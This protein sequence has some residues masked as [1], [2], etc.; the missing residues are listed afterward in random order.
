MQFSALLR[1]ILDLEMANSSRSEVVEFLNFFY[2]KCIHTLIEPIYQISHSARNRIFYGG[3][4][5]EKV[6]W[7]DFIIKHTFGNIWLTAGFLF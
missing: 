4:E 2:Q 1:Q 7:R 3:W 5:V 6:F